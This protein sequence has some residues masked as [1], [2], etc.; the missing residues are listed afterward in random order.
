M[1]ACV[2]PFNLL[3]HH[4]VYIKI[5]ENP[6]VIFEALVHEEFSS[7]TLRCLHIAKYQCTA[8]H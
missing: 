8:N 5:Y 4:I 1:H 6:N 2:K 3:M 7:E